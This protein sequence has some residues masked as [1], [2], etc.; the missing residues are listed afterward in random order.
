MIQAISAA[1][2]TAMRRL[3]AMAPGDCA[4]RLRCQLSGRWPGHRANWRRFRRNDS[5]ERQSERH[6]AD[7]PSGSH[8]PTHLDAEPGQ[9][10][11]HAI[12]CTLDARAPR[13]LAEDRHGF[14]KARPEQLALKAIG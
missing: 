13:N 10:R 14:V 8:R 1:T 5:C 4:L 2:A 3:F 12:L 7:R 9:R 6:R 11:H